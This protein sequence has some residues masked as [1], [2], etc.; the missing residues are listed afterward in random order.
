N[1]I[2]LSG[3]APLLTCVVVR[4]AAYNL[5]R[6]RANRSGR[7]F[8]VRVRPVVSAEPERNERRGLTMNLGTV[9]YAVCALVAA[10][11]ASA[12]ETISFESLDADLTG[13]KPTTIKA[14]LF[15]PSGAGPFSA[16]VLL[17]GCGGLY[18]WQGRDKGQIVQRNAEWAERLAK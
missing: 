6:T 1:R 12:A 8:Y 11:A 17:H 18:R 13:G 14:A 7:V 15:K 16:V 2:C 9:V 10:G 4:C 5:S 3:V